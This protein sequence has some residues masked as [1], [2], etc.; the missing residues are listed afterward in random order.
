MDLS[1]FIVGLAVSMSVA[2]AIFAQIPLI[3]VEKE[4]SPTDLV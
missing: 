4:D 3:M 2:Y 1:I